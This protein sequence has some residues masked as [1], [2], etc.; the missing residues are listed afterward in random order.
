MVEDEIAIEFTSSKSVQSRHLKGLRALKQD[1]LQKKFLL[2]SLDPDA[3]ET[4]DGITLLP[5]E[6][7][8]EKLWRGE[9]F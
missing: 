2:V 5:W 3:R 4:D 6:L 9:I 8:L 7:F 1:Q